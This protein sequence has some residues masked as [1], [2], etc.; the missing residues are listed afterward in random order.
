[1]AASPLVPPPDAVAVRQ[2]LDNLL[3]HYRTRTGQRLAARPGLAPPDPAQV[4]PAPY[5][6]DGINRAFTVYA[7]WWIDQGG[8]R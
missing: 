8:L 5:D 3:A 2:V 4:D 7:Q 1:M 6:A